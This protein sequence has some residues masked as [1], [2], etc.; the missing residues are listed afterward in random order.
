MHTRHPF[1]AFVALTLLLLTS[2]QVYAGGP[3]LLRAPGEPF[4]WPNG[5]RMIPFNPDQGGLGPLTNAQAVAQSTA[6]FQAWADIAS[7][8]A[9][10]A[11]RGLLPVNVDHTNFMPYLFPVAPDGLSAIVYDENGAIF[12]LLFGPGSGVLGFAGPEW[13]DSATGDIMEGVAFMNGGSMLGPGAFPVAEFLSVQVHEYGHYQNLAHTVVNGQILAGPDS[14]GPSP[15]NTFPAPPSFAGRIETMYPFLFIGGGMATPHADDIA[16]FST[17]YPEPSFATTR[18][19]ITGNIVAP[20]NTTPVTGVNVIARNI[21]NPYDDAVSAISSDFTDNFASGNPFVGVYTVR[22]LTP[23]ASYALYVD[24]LLVGD[25][26]TPPRTPLPG[27]EEFYN[28]PTESNDPETDPPGNLFTP[29]VALAGITT[30]DIDIIFNLLPA[31]PIP[32]GDDTS[33]EL[34]PRFSIDFCG[35]RFESLFVNSNGS[36]TFGA[37]DAD[38]S[39]TIAEML[40]GPPRIAALWDDLNPGAAPGSVTFS[41]TSRSLTVSFTNVPEFPN[42]GAN[43]FSLTLFASGRGDGHDDGEDDDEDSWRRGAG[44]RGRNRDGRFNISY[45]ALSATDGLAGYSCGGRITSGFERETD[46]S[47]AARRTIDGDGKAAIFEL[48]SA[49]PGDNDLDNRRLEF[50]G[51]GLFRDVFEPN[52]SAVPTEQHDRNACGHNDHDDHGRGLVRLPFNTADRFSDISPPGGDVDFFRFRAKAGDILAIET[53]PGLQSM[54]TVLGIF[55]ADGNLLLAD[56]DS[57]VGVLSRLLVQVA[58]DG[59]YAVGVSTFPDFGFTGAGGD[60]GRYVLNISSYRGTILPVGDDDGVEVGLSTFAFP[61]QGSNWSS[62][63]VNGN[64]NLTFGAAD[65]DFSESVGE[66]L[67]GPPRIAPLWDDLNAELGLVIAEE[68]DRAL[69][70]H[71]VSVPEFLVTGTNYFSVTLDRRGDITFD[72]GA[73]NRSD[74]IVGVTQGGGAA[75]PGPTDLSQAWRLWTTGTIYEQFTSPPASFGAYGG[76]DL[77]F[78]EVVFKKPR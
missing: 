51:P 75:D 6:A 21:L 44:G 65:P 67:A 62:V 35:Q 12:D 26:S 18:G 5:G 30:P 59:T 34:F 66:L 2:V 39:E 32:A 28:G 58:V 48:F 25:F 76:V 53:V 77:S 22:G 33:T 10:H 78:Q 69:Q 19:S 13:V 37:G 1:L 60:F 73:T 31:G 61:F 4:L 72:Y 45:G 56:D 16:I 15:F 36:L 29:V 20:N 49:A 63:F 40:T 11:N 55:D 47:K 52:D 68:K 23:G 57:G 43:T 3:L 14:R 42:T 24:E 9:T 50:E 8:T 64:G 70:I 41:E 27:P 38:F 7:A 17:L 46:L 74:A 54:D 71:F